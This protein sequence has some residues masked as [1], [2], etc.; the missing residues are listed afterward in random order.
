MKYQTSRRPS[1]PRLKFLGQNIS[2]YLAKQGPKGRLYQGLVGIPVETKPGRYALDLSLDPKNK[3]MDIHQT[4]EVGK[5]GL[6]AKLVKLQ[7]PS[8]TAQGLEVLSKETGQ[9]KKTIKSKPRDRMWRGTFIIPVKGRISGYFGEK[10]VYNKG[11]A[12]WYH[13]G[14]DIAAPANTPI[15]ASNRGVVILAEKLQ[16]HGNTVMIDHGL[17]V[18]SIYLHLGRLKVKPGQTVAKGQVIGLVGTSGISTGNHLHWGIQVHGVAVN[19][20]QWLKKTF[21]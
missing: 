2:L 6:P 3:L 12:T 14:V 11:L 9:L 1:F 7:V 8:L 10:R 21:F 16:E 18:N 13:K 19:P 5:E 15:K 17:G 20:V 4:I